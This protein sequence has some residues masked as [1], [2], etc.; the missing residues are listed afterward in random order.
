MVETANM[1]FPKPVKRSKTPGARS[2]GNKYKAR[3][4]RDESKIARR[5]TDTTGIPFERVPMS[6]ARKNVGLDGDVR[7]RDTV[8]DWFLRWLLELKNKEITN[9][10]GEKQV[11]FALGWLEQ[12][13]REASH[14]RR[15]PALVYR[16]TGDSRLWVVTEFDTFERLLTEL[17]TLSTPPN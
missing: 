14:D 16:Y 13:I 11:T 1:A 12:T 5:L 9:A 2:G 10:R 7:S 8:Q 4:T 17:N 6:G 15:L 3:A